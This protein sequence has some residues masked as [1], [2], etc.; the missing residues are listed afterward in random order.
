[1]AVPGVLRGNP[2]SAGQENA[3]IDGILTVTRHPFLMG[4]TLWSAFHLMAIGTLAA[5]IFFATFLILAVLG[6][7]AIDRKAE[8]RQPTA[9]QEIAAQTSVIP[10]V[11]IGEKRN[12]FRAP[13]VLDWRITVAAVVFGVFVYFHQALFSAPSF[14]ADWLA[15]LTAH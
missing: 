4:V 3:R 6:T 8:R 15:L 12:R 13:E 10:F 7:R 5:T 2:T 11:A 1:L 14:P 9:W